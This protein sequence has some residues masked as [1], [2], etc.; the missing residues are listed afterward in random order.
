MNITTRA[1]NFELT[2]AI[3]RF[4]R[5][6]LRTALARI[7]ESV[8]AVDV[9]LT[10]ANGPRGGVD[11]KVLIRVQMRNRQEV[12]VAT[13]HEDLYAAI[14]KGVKRTKRAVKRKVHK[15]RHF[16]NQRVQDLLISDGMATAP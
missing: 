3:D 11:K 1:Q 12:T 8:I 5:E 9:F 14:S 15:S 10:D 7:D 6:H 16:Q 4:A 13:I 2:R